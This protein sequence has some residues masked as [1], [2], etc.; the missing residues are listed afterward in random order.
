MSS[1]FYTA[2]QSQ[3]TNWAPAPAPAPASKAQPEGD[4]DCAFMKADGKWHDVTCN[5]KMQFICYNGEFSCK[6]TTH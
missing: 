6:I 4:G 3:Y 2:N 1:T 5:T